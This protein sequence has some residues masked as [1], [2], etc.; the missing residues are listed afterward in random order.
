MPIHLNVSEYEQAVLPPRSNFIVIA[1]GH[2]QTDV[3]VV[4]E[5]YRS[6]VVVSKADLARPGR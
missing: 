3:E 4:V 2:E 5:C 1:P 6:Y